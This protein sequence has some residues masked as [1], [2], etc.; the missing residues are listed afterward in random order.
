MLRVVLSAPTINR[1][2][3]I[4]H[5]PT[6]IDAQRG[7]WAAGARLQKYGRVEPHAWIDAAGQVRDGLRLTMDCGSSFYLYVDEEVASD[8]CL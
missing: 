4:G 7:L 3:P 6:L 2:D 8:G 5:A 1:A